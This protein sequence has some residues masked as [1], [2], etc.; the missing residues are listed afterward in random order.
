MHGFADR[1]PLE[2]RRYGPSGAKEDRFQLTVRQES[3]AYFTTVL[4]PGSNSAHATHFHFDMAERRGG[5]RL[6]ELG[7]PNVAGRP[8]ANTKRE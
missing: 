5:Y 3:C 8:P 2:I 4:G 7:E 6:C 1:E